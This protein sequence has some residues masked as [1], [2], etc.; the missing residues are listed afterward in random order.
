MWFQIL[1]PLRVQT[2]SGESA[3]ATNRERTL[4]AALLLQP[5]RV[6]PADELVAAVWPDKPPRNGRGQLQGAVSRLRRQLTAA[7]VTEPVILTD[8][9]GYRAAVGPETLDLLEFRRLR[10][11]ARAAAG[12][13]RHDEA[14]RRYRAALALWRG[15]P[16]ADVAVAGP[17][18]ANADLAEERLQSIE[19]C[20]HSEL[21]SGLTGELVQELSELVSHHPYRER[22]RAALMLALYRAGRQA[23]ALR[24][25]EQGRRLLREE[26][27]TDP[28][29]ELRRLHRAILNHDPSL[30]LPQPSPTPP[31]E[32]APP[33]A[34]AAAPVPRQL[35]G[36]VPSF[37][38]RE[39]SLA[40]LDKLLP[41]LAGTPAPVVISAVAGTAGV[42]KS[43]LVVHWAHRVLDH[44]PDGQLYLDLRGHAAGAPLRPI[45][46]LSWLLRSLAVPAE[47][48]PADPGPAAAMFRSTMAGRRM[49]VL[50][51]NAADAGQVR[52]LLPGAP[53]CLVLVTS[54]AQLTGLVARDGARRLTLEVLTAA[55]STDLLRRLLGA[56]RCAAEPGPVA[57]LAAACAHLPLA[58]RIAAAD[59]DGQPRLPI[60][61]YVAELAG[62]ER[63]AALTT[64]DDEES[65][66]A[67][68]LSHSYRRLSP[69]AAELFRRLGLATGPDIAAPAAAAL[70]DQPTAPTRALLQQ[71]TDAHLLDLPQ[72][73]RFRSHDLLRAYAGEL[74]ATEEPAAAREAARHRL[75]H[76]YLAGADEA[77][78]LLFPTAA[79][80]PAPAGH[81]GAPAGGPIGF[82][83]VPAAMAWLDA[84]RA[85][86]VAAVSDAAER[87]PAPV[88]WLLADRLRGYLMRRQLAVEW[89]V[90]AEAAL[91]AARA[92]GDAAAQASAWHNLA[93]IQGRM[94]EYPEA[95]SGYDT[96]VALAQAAGWREGEVTA[97][98]SQAIVLS[99]TG[100]PADAAAS[101]AKVLALVRDAGDLDGEAAALTGL[102]IINRELGQLAA[103]AEFF[104]QAYEID[105][106]LEGTDG[107]A[108]SLHNLATIH[109][110]LGQLALADEEIRQALRRHR[111]LGDLPGEALG[112]TVQA[113]VERDAGQLAGA[114]VHAEEGLA[115][116]ERINARRCELDARNVL[117]SIL[118]RLDDG[119]GAREQYAAALV[120][121]EQIGARYPQTQAQLGLAEAHR[122]LGDDT[123]ARDHARAALALAES[124]GY[125]LL[126]DRARTLL[127]EL[128]PDPRR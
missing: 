109:L 72:P 85:N 20:L 48:I 119:A 56:E 77:A 95:L 53:G 63:L 98:R 23:D 100:R 13:G 114:R 40:A 31:A 2:G 104:Q 36:A 43:A 8:P 124:V 123:A 126:R 69:A 29:N 90:I 106:Q 6:V 15:V 21:A 70:I 14:G 74:V 112:L 113:A 68:A 120:L 10:D 82:T 102:G 87:G 41:D 76:Y 35:P 12:Q 5:N 46:A 108:T 44:F 94:G 103:A 16:L 52:P 25:Y 60:A 11:A 115:V 91:A 67:T 45:E 116:G 122:Q 118:T 84:E 97:H 4:L 61:D 54:R 24:R 127:A 96:A 55:E 51:D 26:L 86:L 58:L 105:Q 71:L 34:L 79:R 117:G 80:V 1:G 39:E 3:I 32:P 93:K 64:G 7:G 125:Q 75:L 78:E 18:W 28:G 111:E 49:L 59:L 47:Q 101:F 88:A 50:L 17:Q 9:G 110:D 30:D 128:A 22:L 99:A 73:G 37:T 89:R 42:G 38:G 33:P 62:D 65:S 83:D 121:A 81:P 27:G 66:V 19:E 107:L 57:A 92:H